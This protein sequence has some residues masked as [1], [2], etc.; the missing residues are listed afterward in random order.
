MGIKYTH[1]FHQIKKYDKTDPDSATLWRLEILQDS[2]AGASTEIDCDRDSI[3]LSRGG[4][5]LDVVQGSKL[6]VSIINQTEGQYKEF[7][8]ADWGEYEVRLYKDGNN[9]SEL[10]TPI[11]DERNVS[12]TSS[13]DVVDLGNVDGL[14][15]KSAMSLK[16][17]LKISS[18]AGNRAILYKDGVISLLY[19]EF[20]STLT[21]SLVT[22]SGTATAS[23]TLNVGTSYDVYISYQPNFFALYVNEVL[24]AWDN[25]ESGT[26]ASN[27]NDMYIGGYGIYSSTLMEL[28]FIKIYDEI[29]A[30]DSN[31]VLKFVGYNQSEI[32][33]EP[34]NQPPYSSVIEFTCGLN[35]LKNV[36]FEQNKIEELNVDANNT[37]TV[38]SSVKLGSIVEYGTFTIKANT[39]DHS[40]HVVT[41]QTSTDNSVFIDSAFTLTGVG[42]LY[43]TR[44]ADSVNYIRL[45]ITTAEGTASTIDWETNISYFGQKSLIEVLRLCLN[46]LPNPRDVREFVNIYEDSINSAVTDSMLNQIFVDCSVYKEKSDDADNE[47]GIFCND[48]ID[49]CLKIFGVNIYQANGEWVIARVEEY[50]DTTIYYRLFSPYKGNESNLT[51]TSTGSY[52]NNKRLI[53]NPT[54][55]NNELVLVS[56]A[57]ELSIEPPLNR[58]VITY[59]QDN[60]DQ[61]EFDFV[62]NGSFEDTWSIFLGVVFGTYIYRYVPLWWNFVGTDPETYNATRWA[63]WYNNEEQ[64]YFSFDPLTQET[65]FAFDSSIYIEYDK[66]NIPVSTSDSVIL[67]FNFHFEIDVRREAAYQGTP[68]W[69]QWFVDSGAVTFEM[70][71]SLGSYYLHGSYYT[72]FT[73]E[74]SVGQAVFQVSNF[75][76]EQENNIVFHVTKNDWFKVVLPTLPETDL[77]D[78]KIRIYQPYSNIN[79]YTINNDAFD[80]VN[81]Q[82]IEFSGVKLTYLPNEAEATEELILN[83]TIND[84]E[85]LEEIEV[86]HADGTN[87]G[88][89]NS[90]RLSNGIITNQ[91]TRRGLSDDINILELFLQQLAVLRGEYTRELNALV[92]GEM[93]VFNTI[94]HTTDTVNEYYIKT[95]EWNIS[96]SEYNLT[97]SEIG[98]AGVPITILSNPITSRTPIINDTEPTNPLTENYQRTTTTTTSNQV[99]SIIVDQETINN[100][101]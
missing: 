101:I 43:F 34:Y 30:I 2:W 82:F 73:W 93:D 61:E 15:G 83:T 84:G 99:G 51:I 26:I 56:P 67:E 7:R 100:Y 91:W 45:K 38:S 81:D 97:L 46:K 55:A 6:S 37:A 94:E 21:A 8:E 41:L 28:D 1:N 58:V 42:D 31:D 52:T 57:S 64:L 95:Y 96:T 76:I 89:L 22:S 47:E 79:Q 92:I 63:T 33:T 59:N 53:T 17:N 65:A 50:N 4:D 18:G 19:N 49:K 3:V 23:A 98:K 48:V 60:V 12:F 78:F 72:G 44:L 24:I 85:N 80:N 77:V 35:H 40:N 87:T 14:G 32:Y 13:S 68:I 66:A 9:S 70:E 71:I 69:N 20:T 27:T 90:F 74:N 11:V 39:G 5:L 29:V 88:T 25:S 54:T 86:F 75:N 10:P 62:K 16:M 36:R